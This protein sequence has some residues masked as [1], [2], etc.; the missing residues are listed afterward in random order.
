MAGADVDEV[1]RNVLVVEDE[2]I[3]R[4]TTAELVALAGHDVATAGDG[5]AALRV[6]AGGF[7]PDVVVLDLLMPGMDG[8]S[9][10]DELRRVASPA[11]RVVVVT[12]VRSEHLKRL[13]G[14]SEV[15]FKPVGARELLAA[16]AGRAAR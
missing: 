4:E 12:G 8:P 13:L 16:I 3:L 5:A 14:V 9:F 15:L 10:L 2:Q 11:P 7:A 6:I 1:K